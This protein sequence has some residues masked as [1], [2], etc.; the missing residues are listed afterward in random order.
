M[1][2]Q[3]RLIW[4]P[5]DAAAAA[6]AAKGHGVPIKPKPSRRSDIHALSWLAAAMAIFGYALWGSST[7]HA[8]DQLANLS[9]VQFAY[10]ETFGQ[11]VI[12]DTIDT[13]PTIGGVKGVQLAVMDDGF[14][15]GEAQSII[16]VATQSF[17][18]GHFQLIKK[19]EGAITPMVKA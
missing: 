11:G 16:S 17:C 13:Y 10:V 2:T 19:A 1:T 7:A 18:P 4:T 6:Q 3:L 9:H 14:T 15:E 5:A 12:C 8:D